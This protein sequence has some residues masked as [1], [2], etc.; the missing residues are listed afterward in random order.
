MKCTYN[1]PVSVSEICLISADP[2]LYTFINQGVLT[3]DSIDDIEEMKI[4][5]VRKF[6]IKAV[7]RNY[8]NFYYDIVKNIKNQFFGFSS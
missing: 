5:D 6:C 7:S 4:T 1:S 8:H 2:G 3:V